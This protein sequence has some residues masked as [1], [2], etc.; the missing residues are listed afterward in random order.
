MPL[1]EVSVDTLAVII[2]AI[3]DKNGHDLAIYDRRGQSILSDYEIVVSG[4]SN[5]QM[6][7][8]ANAVV[9]VAEELNL[10]ASIEGK[11]GG[12]WILVDLGDVIVHIFDPEARETYQLEKLWLDTDQIEPVDLLES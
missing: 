2:Q 3:E 8:I 1:N 10:N 12:Y 7:A 9:Q 6:T 4:N 11:N 5:R